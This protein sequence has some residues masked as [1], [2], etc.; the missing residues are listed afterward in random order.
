M[1]K[2][3]GFLLLIGSLFPSWGFAQ[4]QASIQL[5]DN[6]N[7]WGWSSWVMDNGIITIA[8]VPEIGAKIMQYDL[9][10]HSSMFVNPDEV[11]KTYTPQSNSSWPNFGGFKNWP[12]PQSRWNWPPPPTLDFGSYEAISES[13]GDTVSLTVTSQIEQWRSPDLRFKRKTSL[14]TGTSRVQ[15]QQTIINEANMAQEWSMWDVTQNI[16]NHPGEEDFDNFRVYFP[17]NPDSEYGSDGVRTSAGSNAWL[18][19]VADGIYGVQFR[20]ESKK[21]FADS[22]LGWIAYVDEREGYMYAKTFDIDESAEYPDDGARVEVW[23]NAD[24]YYLEVE[25]LSPIIN[26]PANGGSYTFTE[27]WWAA[28]INGGPVLA[29]NETGAIT[30]FEY[31]EAIGRLSASFGIFHDAYARLEYLDSDGLIVTATDTIKVT[32]LEVFNYDEPFSPLDNVDSVRMA[33][34]DSD[35]NHIGVLI[36]QS[37]ETLLT[38]NETM[39]ENPDEFTLSQNYPNPFNPSTNIEFSIPSGSQVSLVVFNALGQKVATLVDSRLSSGSHNATWDASTAPSGIYFYQ[40]K[41][42]GFIQSR[43]MLLI[44]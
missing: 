44:K 37:I 30:K 33:L 20:P 2:H 10:T 25:V 39:D 27:D 8:T 5:V 38:S 31:Q 18:G 15:V 21:I 43:K 40:L 14:F 17:I 29:V 23:I 35:L 42:S 41:T 4:S 9:G 1:T 7:E 13:S 22:H 19:E 32:P 34:V 12:A 28:K 24:P 6:Y 26:I 16:T 11:G 36:T 3:I